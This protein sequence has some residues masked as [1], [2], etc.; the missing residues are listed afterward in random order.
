MWCDNRS[1][2]RKMAPSTGMAVTLVQMPM[3]NIKTSGCAL[4]RSS[5]PMI[6]IP[7]PRP[8]TNGTAMLAPATVPSATARPRNLDKSRCKPVMKA[9]S[10]TAIKAIPRNGDTI[11]DR[12]ISAKSSG[13]TRPNSDGPIT[14]P[15]STCRTAS[16]MTRRDL[17]AANRMYGSGTK[18]R[19]CTRNV[20]VND[21]SNRL[22]PF[23]A[24]DA[25]NQAITNYLWLKLPG[26]SNRHCR[27]RA[28][29]GWRRDGLTPVRVPLAKRAFACHPRQYPLS[30]SSA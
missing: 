1:I 30:G 17:K 3:A 16:G 29:F 24:R 23:V 19:H 15:T 14:T 10:S 21:I 18:R 27:H 22:L 20:S 9:K 7:Q 4:A 13:N 28:L 25:L 8:A 11:S 26:R 6:H 5:R 2:S 12:K